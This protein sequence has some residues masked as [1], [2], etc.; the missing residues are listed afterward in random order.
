MGFPA[1]A[2]VEHPNTIKIDE[3]KLGQVTRAPEDAL[4]IVLSGILVQGYDKQQNLLEQGLTSFGI[5]QLI[6]RCAEQGY[7]VRME[8][9]IKDPTFA[10]IVGNMKTE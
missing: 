5:M 10:G 3:P 9:V 6:T 2:P 8:D 1:N 7:R 4:Q